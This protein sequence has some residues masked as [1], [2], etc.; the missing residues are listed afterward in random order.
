MGHIVE[1]SATA[2]A[3][4]ERGFGICGVI[5]LPGGAIGILSLRREAELTRFNAIAGK[6]PAGGT[7]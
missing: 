1:T 2:A 6:S 3:E 5:T 7:T 4:Y